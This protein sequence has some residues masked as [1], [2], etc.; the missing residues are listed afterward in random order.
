MNGGGSPCS[1]PGSG[2]ACT[3]LTG[4]IDGDSGVSV[5]CCAPVSVS[6]NI[7]MLSCV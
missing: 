7:D 1:A 2:G 6:D 3:L 5:L 4:L